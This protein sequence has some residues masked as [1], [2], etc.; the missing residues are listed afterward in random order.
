MKIWMMHGQQ[1]DVG[2]A[3][4]E[5]GVETVV[6]VVV[7]VAWALKTPLVVDGVLDDEAPL[8][9]PSNLP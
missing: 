3:A 9:S 1:K 2:S 5:F 6:V 7:D 8:K 4:A